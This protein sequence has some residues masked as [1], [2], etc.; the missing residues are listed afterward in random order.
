MTFYIL[1]NPCIYHIVST[2]PFKGM[3]D[4][5]F[6]LSLSLIKVRFLFRNERAY[7]QLNLFQEFD[8]CIYN[9]GHSSNYY[10]GHQTCILLNLEEIICKNRK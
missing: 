1:Y 8:S 10:H 5:Y 7:S 2:F 9:I 3:L 6:K 4:S